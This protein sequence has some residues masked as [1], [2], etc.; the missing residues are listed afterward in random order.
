M[1]FRPQLQANS[2]RVA[3]LYTSNVEIVHDLQATLIDEILPSMRG[4]L[5]LDRETE[6]WATE[7][8][9]DTGPFRLRK[10]DQQTIY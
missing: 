6:E 8:L 1:S 10:F 7:W 3:E 5:G 4:E 2:E 9:E